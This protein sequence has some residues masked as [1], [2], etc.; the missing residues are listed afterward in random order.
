MPEIQFVI[1]T[2]IDQHEYIAYDCQLSQ[3]L[4]NPEPDPNILCSFCHSSPCFTDKLLGIQ[5]DLHPVVQQGKQRGQG[6]GCYE[7][8]DEAKLKDLKEDISA[9][10]R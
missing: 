10:Q 5:P 3:H 7:Y 8:G 1:I 6:E 4:H 2:I 9:L